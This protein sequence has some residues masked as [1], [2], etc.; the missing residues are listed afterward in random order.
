MS[1]NPPSTPSRDIPGRD[2][3]PDPDK[4]GTIQFGGRERVTGQEAEWMR[5]ALDELLTMGIE[6]FGA[7]RILFVGPCG[8]PY[9]AGTGD[10][11]CPG[12]PWIEIDHS[13]ESAL[14]AL[15][16]FVDFADAEGETVEGRKEYAHFRA[17]LN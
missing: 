13:W 12:L 9:L 1:S 4:T 5:P 11:D 2:R 8:R 16:R 6:P 7:T 3:L 10:V 14:R 15:Q 17:R